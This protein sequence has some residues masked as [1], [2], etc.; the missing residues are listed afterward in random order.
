MNRQNL[1]DKIPKQHKRRP[2][3]KKLGKL[4]RALRNERDINME[5]MAAELGCSKSYLSQVEIGK[6]PASLKLLKNY[7]EVYKLNDNEA[8]KLFVIA[9]EN[10]N[11]IIIDM[12]DLQILDREYFSRLLAII[13]LFD[14]KIS[15]Y[16]YEAHDL[17]KA[18]DA[19]WHLSIP[20]PTPKTAPQ[21]AL[22]PDTPQDVPEE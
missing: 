6:T 13:K 15:P 3:P 11:K 17:R 2:N 14:P 18:I 21:K 7:I 19:I 20:E 10:F 12:K 9:Y 8:Y 1:P 16:N 5:D 4:F 22:P